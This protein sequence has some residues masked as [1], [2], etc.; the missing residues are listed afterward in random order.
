MLKQSMLALVVLVMTVAPALGWQTPNLTPPKI[1]QELVTSPVPPPPVVTQ[2]GP[3]FAPSAPPFAAP[4]GRFR[5][6]F[7]K[8][9][10]KAAR[11]SMKANA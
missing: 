2:P 3:S 10:G 4:P 5:C 11:H 8:K 6:P 1:K 9:S 7:R